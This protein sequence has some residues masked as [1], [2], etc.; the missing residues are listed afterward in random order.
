MPILLNLKSK[1]RNL[2]RRGSLAKVIMVRI[3]LQ[4]TLSMMRNLEQKKNA[5]R[6]TM[7]TT[8]I[9]ITLKTNYY[10][11]IVPPLLGAVLAHLPP[12]RA[13]G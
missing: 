11:K 10:H 7:M 4:E 9:M 1:D 13:M 12:L 2:E 5:R 8:M 6:M 3:K